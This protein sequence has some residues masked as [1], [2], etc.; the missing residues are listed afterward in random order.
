MLVSLTNRMIVVEDP[1]TGA[2]NT[3][4]L[5]FEED[6]ALVIADA[7]SE[8]PQ[9]ITRVPL[10]CFP[11]DDVICAAVTGA[12]G[13]GKRQLVGALD[14]S[15]ELDSSALSGLKKMPV[16]IFDNV[17][18]DEV[19]NDALV[20]CV[21]IRSFS[22]F[23][24]D[25]PE[26]AVFKLIKDFTSNLLSCINQFAYG[27]SYY[28]LMGDG[29]III[30]DTTDATTVTE[31]L[32]VFDTY[33]EFLNEELFRNYPDLGL[34]G[35]L[36][37]GKV[38]KY[39]ISAEASQLKYRDYVGYGINLAC[40]LQALAQ[41]NEL[42]INHRLADTTLVPYRAS[43]AVDYVRSLHLLKGLKDEDCGEV[44]FYSPNAT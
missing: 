28:K 17:Y 36:V 29:A 9:F 20:L 15:L 22:K 24:C 6:G 3:V 30:W 40:R 33:V 32:M 5:S 38:F 43:C 42:V 37:T 16:D 7:D 8:L 19:K 10:N 23:L 26:D 39:E 34:G 11:T 25:N 13:G 41:R 12:L 2:R 14:R 35:A 31:G 21:D 27:C 44:L 4:L 1:A 18:L